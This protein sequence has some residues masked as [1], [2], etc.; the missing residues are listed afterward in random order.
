MSKNN[1]R[2][3]FLGNNAPAQVPEKPVPAQSPP[4]GEVSTAERS[5]ASDAAVQSVIVA[6]SDPKRQDEHINLMESKGYR[7]YESVIIFGNSMILR[8]RR[9]TPQ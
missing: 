2:N 1:Q 4:R 7:H 3:N 8:F 6:A 5:I 9:G